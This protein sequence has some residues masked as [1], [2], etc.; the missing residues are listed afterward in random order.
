M[1]LLICE[2]WPN[3]MTGQGVKMKQLHDKIDKK[4][5]FH[6]VLWKATFSNT[7]VFFRLNIKSVSSTF[8]CLFCF[9]SWATTSHEVKL[10]QPLEPRW[11]TSRMVLVLHSNAK[12]LVLPPPKSCLSWQKPPRRQDHSDFRWYSDL[13]ILHGVNLTVETN[14]RAREMYFDKPLYG[15]FYILLLPLDGKSSDQQVKRRNTRRLVS[16]I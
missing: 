5:L 1:P 12:H 11:L 4:I 10:A 3:N 9:R 7:K 8:V 16:F 2:Y 15:H 6:T 13:F 14:K